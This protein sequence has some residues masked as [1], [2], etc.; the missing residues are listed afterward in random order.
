MAV[1]WDMVGQIFVM[2]AGILMLL[3]L[4]MPKDKKKG[5]KG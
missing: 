3:S 2:I 1:D 4:M 5:A